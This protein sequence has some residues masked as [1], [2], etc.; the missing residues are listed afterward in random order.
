MS[1][2][3]V[4]G[5]RWVQT[6]RARSLAPPPVP[7][8]VEKRSDI[9]SFSKVEGDRTLFTVRAARTTE[10]KEGGRAQLEDVWITIYG[11]SAK[12]FDNIHTR[13]CDYAPKTGRI[14]CAGEVQFDLESAEEAKTRPGERT[15][16]IGT[17]GIVFERESGEVRTENPVIFHFPYGHGRGKGATYSTRDAVFRLHSEIELTLTSRTGGERAAEPVK[18]TGAALEYT[19]DSHTMRLLAPVRVVQGARELLAGQL[20][21]EL[22]A[23]LR[24]RRLLAGGNPRL[25]SV[26]PQGQ[27]DLTASDIVTTFN[28]FSFAE[29]ITATN[30]VT[31]TL[32]NSSSDDRISA[33]RVEIGM[34]P[35]GNRPDMLTASGTVAFDSSRGEE[36][37]R[38]RTDSLQVKFSAAGRVSATRI[39]RAET[40]APAKIEFMS[41]GERTDA[42]SDR[43]SAQF[44]EASRVRRMDGWGNSRIERRLGDAPALLTTSRDLA[45]TFDQAGNWSTAELSGDVRYAE[46]GRT[47][48]A[49]RAQLDR[50]SDLLTL[51]GNASVSDA[52]ARITAQSFR[53]QQRSGELRGEGGVRTTYFRAE[54]DGLTDFAPQPAHLS[55]DSLF[56]NRGNGRAVYSGHGRLWQG[57]AVI[58][59]E[60]IE[61]F[62][63][64]KR[65][66]ARKNVNALFPQ[67][68]ATNAPGNHQVMWRVRAGKLTYSSKVSRAEIEE[69]VTAQSSVGQMAS[70]VLWLFLSKDRSGKQLLGRAVATGGVTIR[71]GERRGSADR[72]E[73]V[74]SEGKFILSGGNPT[75]FDAHLGTTSGRQLTFFLAD[76]RILVDSEEGS[77][78]ISRHRVE[79]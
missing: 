32:K 58:E 24:A 43:L 41:P 22:D 29:R 38:L 42:S 78:T 77:R 49:D 48:Q 40:L 53:F 16:H 12:R 51:S 9:F 67:T 55:S 61:L 27:F 70:R 19:R 52:Q 76:D 31:A 20:T 56:V 30:R 62:R 11:R 15:I 33:D 25:R 72:G 46:G 1:V 74:V 54:R 57:D 47:A 64:E 28:S 4:Y 5:W 73:Y 39:D 37:R 13:E 17:M 66:E 2:I 79:N 68:A 71:Q 8:E 18:L 45:V 10:F 50:K 75:L 63:D 7:V 14:T 59:A 36:Q 3:G 35:L 69:S 44:D 34:L 21:L 26:E 65:L 60:T 6:R 23:T